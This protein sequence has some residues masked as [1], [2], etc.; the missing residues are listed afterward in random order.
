MVPQR[1]SH[2]S[3]V[4]GAK[5]TFGEPFLCGSGKSEQLGCARGVEGTRAVGHGCG[6]QIVLG[7]H[8]GW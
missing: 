2:P 6:G 8:F 5:E 7:S 4:L 1:I 3:T